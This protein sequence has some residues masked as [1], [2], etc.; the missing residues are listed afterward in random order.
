MTDEPQPATPVLP[1]S[2][3][4]KSAAECQKIARLMGDRQ[5][6]TTELPGGQCTKIVNAL[7]NAG[8]LLEMVALNAPAAPSPHEIRELLGEVRRSLAAFKLSTEP[9]DRLAVL[10]GV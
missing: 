7:L 3:Y 9:A 5:N 1:A 8:N 4:S 6:R 10:L 2:P